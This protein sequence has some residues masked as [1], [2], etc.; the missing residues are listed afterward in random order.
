MS[1]AAETLADHRA[2]K[3]DAAIRYADAYRKYI[4]RY[5]DEIHLPTW[6]RVATGECTAID[7]SAK[8]I[9]VDFDVLADGVVIPEDTLVRWDRPRLSASEVVNKRVKVFVEYRFLGAEDGGHQVILTLA[10]IMS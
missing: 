3:E 9:E 2:R 5:W 8:T 4:K 1:G 6:I 10:A 7:T